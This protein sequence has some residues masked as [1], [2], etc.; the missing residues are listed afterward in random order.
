M[1]LRI[2]GVELVMKGYASFISGTKTADKTVAQ[3][4][5]TL[6]RLAQRV[7]STNKSF[8][9][10][11]ARVAEAALALSNAQLKTANAQKEID[12]AILSVA[13][14]KGP[15]AAQKAAINLEKANN[16]LIIAQHNEITAILKQNA[17][18]E[19]QV[20]V[21]EAN[22]RAIA[23]YEVA[24]EQLSQ[25]KDEAAKTSG[26][27]GIM[28]SFQTSL[29]SVIPGGNMLVT[30]L[31]GMGLAG[32]QIVPVLGAIAGGLAAINAAGWLVQKALQAIQW[33]INLV[34]NVAK[35]LGNIVVGAFKTIGGI[36]EWATR[37]LRQFLQHVL[38]IASGIA[39][40]RAIREA[41]EIVKNLAAE[42]FQAAANFQLLRIQFE[43]I[44]ARDYANNM[45]VPLAEAFRKTA[46]A[47]E[48]LFDWVR[49][50]AVTTLYGAEEIADMVTRANAMGLTIPVAK[51]LTVA[52]T[53]MASA[54]GVSNE[55]IQRVTYN[56]SQMIPRNKVMAEE[57]RQLAH[58]FFPTTQVIT[59]MA[60]DAGVSFNEMYE[61]ITT[62]FGYV[63]PFLKKFIDL[64]ARDFPN[65]A[66]RAA[67]TW[68]GATQ[69]I[70]DFINTFLGL[71]LVLPV[72]D[73]VG[74][75]LSDLL[76]KMISDVRLQ[77][78]FK[79]L[80][81]V[82]V[83]GFEMITPVVDRLGGAFTRL[84]NAFAGVQEPAGKLAD[85][86]EVVGV[87]SKDIYG[88]AY[89]IGVA[90]FTAINVVGRFI[91]SITK[92]ITEAAGE[93]SP[94]A[95]LARKAGEWGKKFIEAFAKGISSGLSIL[96]SVIK[97]IA[98]IL[99]VFKPG[100]PPPIAPDIDKWGA[101]TMEEWIKG[102][103][104][105]DFTIF[106]DVSALVASYIKSLGEDAIAKQDVIPAIMKMRDTLAMALAGGE[107]WLTLPGLGANGNLL[108]TYFEAMMKISPIEETVAKASE[109]VAAAQIELDKARAAYDAITEDLYGI[110]AAEA[111]VAKASKL[112]DAIQKEI[113][114]TT[115][116][117]DK[118]IGELQKKLEQITTVYDENQRLKEID[119]A[120]SSQHLTAQERERL[121]M[122]K[123]A[124]QIQREIRAQEDAKDAEIAMLQS[125]LD[126]AKEV[127]ASA[128]ARLDDL[129]AQ[130]EAARK[131]QD[132]QV[133]TAEKT[134]SAAKAEEDA[135]KITLDTA[136]ARA[137]VIKSQIEL[138]I[139]Q[140][141]LLKEQKD[142]LAALKEDEG[143]LTD[144]NGYVPPEI[145]DDSWMKAIQEQINQAVKDADIAAQGFMDNLAE[146]GK[147]WEQ[148]GVKQTF[149]EFKLSIK[150]LGEAILEIL[151]LGKDG[152]ESPFDKL[153]IAWKS[154]DDWLLPPPG[155]TFI[156]NFAKHLK[157]N[158]PGIYAMAAILVGAGIT[159]GIAAR[160]FI[161]AA[162]S[163]LNDPI[164]AFGQNGPSFLQS[165]QNYA[166]AAGLLLDTVNDLAKAMGILKESDTTTNLTSLINAIKLAGTI[167]PNPFQPLLL[168]ALV[169]NQAMIVFSS[170][171]KLLKDAVQFWHDSA[172]LM[173]ESGAI[174]PDTVTA[175]FA[176]LLGNFGFR[177]MA[178]NVQGRA[179]GGPVREG[180][181]YIVGEKRP[182]LFWPD[183]NGVIFPEISGEFLRQSAQPVSALPVMGGN[184]DNSVNIEVNPTYSQ[185]QSEADIYYDVEAALGMIYR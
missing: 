121:E 100:S 106:N 139:E 65:A 185:V 78:S 2:S 56:L 95:S 90:F 102:F 73:A 47:A 104:Q 124:I 147:I 178:G 162:N 145:A 143:G 11:K 105:A 150:G 164:K 38:E 163:F 17:A 149:E 84:F 75:K 113:T 80:G 183:Q 51:N 158:S 53:N 132:I 165:I 101:A 32:S 68:A 28:Q 137:E 111:E 8:N 82:L 114:S 91:D 22:S 109:A 44:Q 140:N 128:Q 184:V 107:N 27:E 60:K 5:K 174:S 29:A 138:I 41:G 64:M 67:H 23:E 39:L 157:E 142:I 180:Q 126:A 45:A 144:K 118:V 159:L 62:K 169:F 57:L 66:A 13:S 15:V 6:D 59:E 93:T 135:A 110:A 40:W 152:G 167:I 99:E 83:R 72:L 77:N 96:T 130:Y 30:I 31:E 146:I 85:D 108:Q 19:Q 49:R 9:D 42:I 48:T 61:T 94:I 141:N 171:S 131:L 175:F 179:G 63:Q 156:G 151:G 168:A 125:Q 24:Q 87:K 12:K 120:L 35:G 25:A 182:E 88:W 20:M 74:G 55:N 133:Q 1:A 103:T 122:E 117:Y 70:K 172:A 7:A 153:K 16:N 58:E 160:L 181:P 4:E 166:D 69:N 46:G 173:I 10:A 116:R 86:L 136:K 36:I 148:S 115:E 21:M 127:E 155:E 176:S 123:Q 97:G 54:F 170:G 154:I 33:G 177:L 18:L 71:D 52:V 134:L 34:I 81:Q 161:D 37:P 129:K 98:K 92:R 3:L 43:S 76:N 119:A 26:M 50:L 79:F 112:A 89:K 14:A